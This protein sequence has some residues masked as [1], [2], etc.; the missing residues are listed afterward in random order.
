MSLSYILWIEELKQP[1]LVPK[2]NKNEVEKTEVL[3][4]FY[5]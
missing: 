2:I 5:I 3:V 1:Y 4:V